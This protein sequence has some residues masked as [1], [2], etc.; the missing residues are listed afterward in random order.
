MLTF[1]RC[2]AAFPVS[3]RKRTP[4]NA[5]DGFVEQLRRADVAE[6][7]VLLQRRISKHVEEILKLEKVRLDFQRPLGEYGLNSIMGLDLRHR[8]ERDLTLRL[9]ATLVWNYP[10]VA[11]LAEHLRSCLDPTSA[12]A[13]E[14]N[15]SLHDR[16]P[17][18]ELPSSAVIAAATKSV[19]A[20]L[21]QLEELSEE[22]ALAALRAPKA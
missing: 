10:T 6:R 14:T 18:G 7:V 11:A 19:G 1:G 13:V 3:S 22:A 2:F 16:Q 8:L 9:S 17:H 4:G 21:T 5:R 20:R 15:A 12:V